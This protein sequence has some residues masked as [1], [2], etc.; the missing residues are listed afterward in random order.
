VVMSYE[1]G[2]NWSVFSARTAPVLGPLLAF[3][4]LTAFFLE[5]SFLGVMLF[6]WKKVG[7]G[8]HFLATCLVAVGTLISAFWIISA[9]SWMQVPAGHGYAGDG[10]LVAL[11]WWT[12]IFSPTFPSR[13]VH[14]VLAAYLT[15]A[16]VVGAVV[17]FICAKMGLQSQV[18]PLPGRTT[19]AM[20]PATAASK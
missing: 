5:A 8:L 14:M 12:V 4:V 16:F 18:I 15:T 7:P 10:S 9:N 2:A 17:Y 11:D 19:E 6:G 1:F 20:R 13:L 3:E